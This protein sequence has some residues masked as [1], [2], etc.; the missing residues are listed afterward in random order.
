MPVV[1]ILFQR[2][3][4]IFENTWASRVSRARTRGARHVE[5]RRADAGGIRHQ[6]GTCHRFSQSLVYPIRLLI[7]G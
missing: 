4:S 3:L 6:R 5:S 1:V 2:E 7:V